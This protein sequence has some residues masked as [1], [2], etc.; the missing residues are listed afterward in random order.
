[1]E[2]NMQLIKAQLK[3]RLG[4]NRKNLIIKIAGI[5]LSFIIHIV[6]LIFLP[7]T[8]LFAF[9]F[10]LMRK[11]KFQSLPFSKSILFK[12]G[13][14]PIIDHYYEPMFNPKYLYKS[15]RLKRNLPGINLNVETQLKLLSKFLFCEELTGY[16]I[17][18]LNDEIEFCYKD[19]PSPPPMLSTFII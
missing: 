15:L 6:D 16:P 17:E 2:I 8:V 12:I 18:K 13:V 10:R 1:M 4:K 11:R 9:F 14:Y 5:L 7:I 19:G 3:K